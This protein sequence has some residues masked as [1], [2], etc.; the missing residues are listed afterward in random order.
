MTDDIITG[1]D[2]QDGWYDE[3]TATFGDRLAGAREAA[4]LTKRDWPVVW[5]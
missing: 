2:I 1:S 5:G 3:E 4:S